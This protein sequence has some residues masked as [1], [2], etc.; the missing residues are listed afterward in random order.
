MILGSCFL[1]V[2]VMLPVLVLIQV[3]DPISATWAPQKDGPVKKRPTFE[4]LCLI[5]ACRPLANHL[6]EDERKTRQTRRINQITFFPS[7][8]LLTRHPVRRFH[9]WITEGIR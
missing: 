6:N 8:R 2:V 9:K 7:S 3:C 5:W 4:K 1:N